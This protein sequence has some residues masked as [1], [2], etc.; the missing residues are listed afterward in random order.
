MQLLSHVW[1]FE[2]LIYNIVFF[3]VYSKVVWL[4]IYMYMFIFF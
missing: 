3:Q 4:Y 1:L 2:M